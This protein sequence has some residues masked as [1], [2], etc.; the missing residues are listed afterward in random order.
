MAI[1]FLARSQF[2][3]YFATLIILRPALAVSPDKKREMPQLDK[4]GSRDI[5]I[6]FIIMDFCTSI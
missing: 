3:T 2:L 1:L 6:I 4:E 5:V